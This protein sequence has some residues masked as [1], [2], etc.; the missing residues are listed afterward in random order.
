MCSTPRDPVSALV[1]SVQKKAEPM[2]ASAPQSL[3]GN[4][5]IIASRRT[6]ALRCAPQFDARICYVQRNERRNLALGTSTI[7][8]A[9]SR[10]ATRLSAI[11]LNDLFVNLSSH[12]DDAPRI[13]AHCDLAPLNSTQRNE[14]KL[15]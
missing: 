12:L 4:K 14:L 2:V 1:A 5:F 15:N 13:A 6:T 8:N 7:R 10:I 11:Q 9:T 3:N